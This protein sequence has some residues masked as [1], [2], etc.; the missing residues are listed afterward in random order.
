MAPAIVQS[1]WSIRIKQQL[2]A[3]I[4]RSELPREER[5]SRARAN[6]NTCHLWAENGERYRR[7]IDGS[8]EGE[9]LVPVANRLKEL[10]REDD[11]HW[12]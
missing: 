11:P 1:T 6:R 12:S 7:Y 4:R 5:E 8:L 10:G 3:G 2:K 9:V